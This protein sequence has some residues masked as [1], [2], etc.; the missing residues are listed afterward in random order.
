MLLRTARR[1]WP[2]SL[3]TVS[4]IGRYVKT[5]VTTTYRDES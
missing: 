5:F 2:V 1:M 4:F 3:G